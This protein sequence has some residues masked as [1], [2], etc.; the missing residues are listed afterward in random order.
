MS[1]IVSASKLRETAEGVQPPS[2]D[3]VASFKLK[4]QG[5]LLNNLGIQMYTKLGK[6]LVEF[7]ANAFDSDSSAVDIGFDV[8]RIAAAR[9][10]VRAAAKARLSEKIGEVTKDG[11][12]LKVGK[13]RIVVDP[14][15]SD[16]TVTISDT[17]H[18]MTPIEIADRL[19]PI[20]RN[21][22]R[23][24]VTGSEKKLLSEAGC[25]FVMGR[26]GIG[27][28]SAFGAADTVTVRSKRVGQCYWT[29]VTLRSSQ[30]LKSND[31]GEVELDHAY[32]DASREEVASSG[33]SIILSD[34]RCDAVNFTEDDLRAILNETFYP[35][36]TNEF[37][38]RL[39]GIVAEKIEPELEYLYPEGIAADAYSTETLRD[40]AWGELDFHYRVRF[41]KK[42]LPAEKRGAY[43]YSKDR[44]A[45]D[46]SLLGLNTG[47]HNFMAHQ[48]MECFVLSDD[49]DNLEVDVIGT[50]RAGIIRNSDLVRAFL[51]RI[52]AI[53][54]E[55]IKQHAAFRDRVADKVIDEASSARRVRE[56]L[57]V[58]PA[59]QRKAARQLAKIL[60]AQ[61]GA[62]SEEFAD[63]APL[64]MGRR[65]PARSLST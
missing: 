15:P 8:T 39:N 46:P 47:T 50:N 29:L 32:E 22:R 26:K 53:M 14:L 31:M 55:A 30:L 33:T 34:L 63:V 59:G 11:K 21:R 42:S 2:F 1:E 44:L 19:L 18:G 58:V 25:R 61:Y 43:I 56:I 12:K 37:A 49:L 10:T 3:K 7:A 28:L 16:I 17:G 62:D 65:T 38:I 41:R 45:A 20:N 35:I 40:E 9:E 5:G 60:V 4:I 6:V 51:D 54:T 36:K 57:D 52:T 27:K 23:D 48:Y 13:A 24:E 64:I